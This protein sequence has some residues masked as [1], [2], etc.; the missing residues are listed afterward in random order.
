[1]SMSAEAQGWRFLGAAGSE[2]T[3]GL[4]LRR[5]KDE[6]VDKNCNSDFCSGGSRRL[7]CVPA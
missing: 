3:E 1:M 4:K 5:C 7:V 6:K 2:S